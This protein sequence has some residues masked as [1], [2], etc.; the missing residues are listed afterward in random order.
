MPDH[1]RLILTPDAQE[2]IRQK[3]YE[4]GFDHLR[5]THDLILGYAVSI[6]EQPCVER[7]D[8]Q[9]H[10]LARARE[11]QKRI[12]C[13]S[14]AFRMTGDRRWLVRA[15]K[16][17]LN[18]CSYR[19]WDPGHFLDTAEMMFSLAMGY[20]WLYD[21]LSEK[22]RGIIEGALLH[23]GLEAADGQAFYKVNHNWNQVCNA[24]VVSTCL[25]LYETLPSLADSLIRKSL[26]SNRLAMAV[27]APD[28][29]YPEGDMYWDY[30]TSFE[31][32]MIESLRSSL[33][34]DSGIP[35]SEGFLQT[36]RFVQF[37]ASP[38]GHC[39][40]FSD[41]HPDWQ[42]HLMS[43][44]FARETGDPSLCLLERRALCSGRLKTPERWWPCIMGILSQVG[45]PKPGA[46]PD[47]I[48]FSRGVN[49]V[50][51]YRSGW[52][53]PDDAY[54]AVKGGN[55]SLNH[56]HM[57][58]GSFFFEKDGTVWAADLGMQSYGSLYKYGIRIWD[59]SQ[60]G[61]R[62]GVFR[63]GPEAHNVLILG[64]KRPKVDAFADI[65]SHWDNPSGKGCR[66]DLS[67]TYSNV[68]PYV[69]RS[70][71][72]D[73]SNRVLTVCDSLETGRDSLTLVWN[74]VTYGRPERL[75]DGSV[76][77]MSGNK[78]MILACRPGVPLDA[79]VL[80][81]RSEHPW[82]APNPRAYRVGFLVSV[83]P[84]T[85]IGLKVSLTD[86]TP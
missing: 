13:L 46:L 80:P 81:A 4:P 22:T 39:F 45:D 27:Y 3:L 11:V 1:P 53:R 36:G 6:L 82:D 85:R 42:P 59:K 86:A 7:T 66:V 15:E 38:G 84:R 5:A 83:P 58:S 78:K 79:F 16:E 48:F 44:W 10:I 71:N 2:E 54:L 21:R 34:F 72:L 75:A 41:S 69:S 28:G 23:K 19:D 62:W 17:M 20:D 24:A 49:P 29:G 50:W 8:T 18:A 30:G 31:I 25:A 61:Q 60:E 35:L 76:L 74:M 26:S 12:L 64:E 32:L 37:L 63:Y 51:I 52:D 68:V 40:S 57:D 43:F 47:S 14:Y 56:A 77:L 67:E 70:V 55:P 33:G 65:A 73:R 9:G